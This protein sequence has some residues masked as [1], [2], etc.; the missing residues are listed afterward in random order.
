MSCNKRMIDI[1]KEINDFFA[2]EKFKKLAFSYD[3]VCR[4]YCNENKFHIFDDTVIPSI[5]R[6]VNKRIKEFVDNDTVEMFIR[7]NGI[8]MEYIWNQIF[9]LEESVIYK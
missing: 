8:Y 6:E 7:D 5:S 9:L 3:G 2:S 1:E 4:D